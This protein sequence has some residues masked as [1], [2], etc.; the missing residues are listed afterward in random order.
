MV[1]VNFINARRK[2]R[3]KVLKLAKGYFGSKSKLYKTAHEQ[4]MRSLQYAYRDRRRK[5]RDFRKL[6]ITRI[7]AGCINCGISYSLF[8]HGLSLANIE[9]N[10]KML[11]DLAFQDFEMFQNYVDIAKAKLEEKE[12]QKN[13]ILKINE[14]LENA[15]NK[16]N[17]I[18]NK[19]TV[20][21]NLENKI[22]SST[23]PPIAKD[24]LST[25]QNKE[26][27]LSQL[28]NNLISKTRKVNEANLISV[29]KL[30]QMLLSDLKKIAKEYNLKN[31]SKLKKKEIIDHLIQ[32]IS[33]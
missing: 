7:N 25:S 32:V 29:E 12:C 11:S 28:E 18:A 23:N 33:K 2:R 5:K 26:E 10:R 24:F 14:K 27:E 8:I 20:L 17:I 16:I 13:K 21:N 9:I 3:K 19:S 31:I 15:Q 4:V 30:N 22:D 6:W 1:K